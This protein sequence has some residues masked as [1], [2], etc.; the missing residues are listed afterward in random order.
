MKKLPVLILLFMFAFSVITPSTSAKAAGF[1]DV[2][3]NFWA[4]GEI[5][6]LANLN[7]INGYPNGTFGVNDPVKR[8]QVAVMLYRALE[9]ES[10][11]VSDPGFKDVKPDHPS[12]KEIAACVEFGLFDRSEFFNPDQKMTRAQM[13]KVLAESFNLASS[14]YVHFKD[15]KQSDWYYNHVQALANYNITVGTD[16]YFLPNKALTRAEFSVF[17]ARMMDASYR[18]GVN[19]V[20]ENATYDANGNLVVELVFYNNTSHFITNI[21][22][23]FTLFADSEQIASHKYSSSN[24]YPVKFNNLSL[25]PKATKTVTVQFKPEEISQKV[26][27]TE[28]TMLEI[29]F[30]YEYHFK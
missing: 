11:N 23:R 8:S 13:A 4:Y 18:P 28:N 16:G 1:K 10:T 26:N 30:L 12:Y 2:P 9:L 3:E 17:L 27:I 20:I 22:S 15:V 24:P 29:L 6:F 5:H 19:A 21:N 7:I 14:I 25:A